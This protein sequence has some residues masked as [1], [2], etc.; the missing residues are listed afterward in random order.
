[1]R[2]VRTVHLSA[3]NDGL[4]RRGELLLEDALHTASLPAADG[5]WLWLVRSLSVG[6]IDPKGSSASLALAIERQLAQLGALALHGSDPGADTA[7]VVY[8]RTSLE[9][10][11]LLALR[12]CRGGPIHGWFWSVAVPTWQPGTPPQQALRQ[13]LRGTFLLPGGVAAVAQFVQALVLAQA[14]APLMASLGLQDGPL[15][16]QACGWAATAAG[17]LNSG[18]TAELPAPWRSTL[19]DAICQ[20][21]ARDGRT[22]WLG[23]MALVAINPSRLA[24]PV[25][26]DQAD[27]VIGQLLPSRL[28]AAAAAAAQQPQVHQAPQGPWHAEAPPT[29]RL[30]PD[31]AGGASRRKPQLGEAPGTPAQR[32]A[33]RLPT[34]LAPA[35]SPRG[36]SPRRASP[37]GASS[38][39]ANPAEASPFGASTTGASPS[40]PNGADQ[41]QPTPAFNLAPLVWSGLP[42]CNTSYAGFLF[43]IPLLSQL[44]IEAWLDHHPQLLEWDWPRHL[45]LRIAAQL[46]IPPEDPVLAALAADGLEPGPQAVELNSISRHWSKILRRW[47]QA[48]GRL[49]LA[50][51]VRRPGSL[52]WQRTHLDLYFDHRQAEIRVRRLGLDLD[53]GWV[54]WLALVVQFHYRSGGSSDGG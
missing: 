48:P 42:P 17:P 24:D 38:S 45:L 18:R 5:G 50:A 10:P 43:L 33:D 12:L 32:H 7:P 8:F 9:A 21:G 28:A 25:L 51:L 26:L 34:A 27:A 2:R 20:W 15:L 1:M 39:G 53:P 31:P 37:T 16:L 46:G 6:R 11:I 40:K 22:L 54:S 44:N 29:G 36:A 19:L 3:P 35:A 4:L 52:V 41:P 23:A 47:S 14:S 30:A 49:S 13:I